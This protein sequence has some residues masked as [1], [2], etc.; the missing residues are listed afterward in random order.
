MRHFVTL[1][2]LI[3]ATLSSAQSAQSFF[4]AVKTGNTSAMSPL[5]AADIELC[6][7]SDTEMLSRNEALA[8]IKA[9]LTSYKPL[10]VESMHGGSNATND[11]KYQVAKLK[12]SNGTFRIFV[13]MEGS[14]KISEVRFDAF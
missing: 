6:I 12:T 3:A 10:A 14:D 8:D 11:S 9:F 7:K 2:L 5:L 1:L 4:D 13:Y